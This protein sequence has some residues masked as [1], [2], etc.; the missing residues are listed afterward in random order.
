[1]KKI[2]ILLKF[3]LKSI[4]HRF[5]ILGDVIKYSLEAKAN[6]RVNPQPKLSKLR[7]NEIKNY[8]SSIGHKINNT[9]SHRFYVGVYG[10][11]SKYFIPKTFFYSRLES[12]L[13]R[14][15]FNVLQDKNLLDRL[16]KN[17]KQPVCIIKNINGFFYSESSLLSEE[18]A[19]KKIN[20]YDKFIIKPS[21]ES[22]GG[23]NIKI[24]Q[25]DIYS[26]LDD[27]EYFKSLFNEYKKDYVIQEVLEQNK[28]MAKLN[29]SS[30]N[31]IR[32]C[33]YLRLNE[34]VILSAILRIGQKGMDVD[35]SSAGGVAVTI[36][37]SGRL[38]K[39]AYN[40]FNFYE[41]KL[42]N[43]VSLDKFCVPNYDNVKKKVQELHL[44]MPY[45]RVI[46]WDI[47]I[48]K[49]DEPVLLEMNVF[50]QGIDQ[51]AHAGP[52]FAGYTDEI[53]AIYKSSK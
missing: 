43:N 38:Q 36:E 8:Y 27:V 33:S 28:F 22:G 49:N 31:T 51:Q 40:K 21:I 45:F 20:K 37:S 3:I 19:I 34:V 23:K 26:K 17:V 18:E 9:N 39:K 5:L 16:L 7:K 35:N 6:L 11:F 46:S 30:I 1:M 48:D 32:I 15:E 10:E 25:K 50:G 52:F 44:Q 42:I 53:L 14:H 13:N 41:E 24:I 4:Q 47:A 2:F 12:V 29:P